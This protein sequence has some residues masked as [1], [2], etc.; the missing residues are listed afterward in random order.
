MDR[1]RRC[2]FELHLASWTRGSWALLCVVWG[3]RFV[4]LLLSVI[5]KT[6]GLWHG[7][8][9]GTEMPSTTRIQ[10]NSMR[11]LKVFRSS[12]RFSKTNRPS[13]TKI[14]HPAHKNIGAPPL[15]IWYIKLRAM[16]TDA[17]PLSKNHLA[18]IELAWFDHC[19]LNWYLN[20]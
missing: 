11:F 17:Y 13:I 7:K 4:L 9:L 20:L 15:E 5:S 1:L 2:C 8:G 6:H 19:I 14:L 3:G 18:L 12:F 10:R 16:L